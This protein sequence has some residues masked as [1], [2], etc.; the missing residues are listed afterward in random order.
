MIEA[1]AHV[2]DE[3]FDL[4]DE[5]AKVLTVMRTASDTPI[6]LIEEVSRIQSMVSQVV[7]LI[8]VYTTTHDQMSSRDPSDALRRVREL[9]S[10]AKA[11]LL[12]VRRAGVI[13]IDTNPDD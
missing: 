13:G 10:G 8:I 3:A 5:V 11:M 4:A 2:E 1:L 9:L 6:A 7:S 12:D